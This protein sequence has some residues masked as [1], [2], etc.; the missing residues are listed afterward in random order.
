MLANFLEIKR[1]SKHGGK[2]TRERGL[3]F[4][5]FLCAISWCVKMFET[6][7]D[8][9]NFRNLFF[10]FRTKI[11]KNFFPHLLNFFKNISWKFTKK[12]WFEVKWELRC[13][14]NKMKI[15]NSI[16]KNCWF[17]FSTG[18]K[19]FRFDTPSPT[20]IVPPPRTGIA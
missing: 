5:Y 3:K 19:S 11:F 18:L 6:P 2:L 14:E 13:M 7:Q 15:F 20:I 4:I 9:W 12:R 8:I 10:I 16:D 1:K 17:W